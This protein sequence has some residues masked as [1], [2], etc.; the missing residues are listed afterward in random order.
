MRMLTFDAMQPWSWA[1]GISA[2][3]YVCVPG[4][5]EVFQISNESRKEKS[6][7]KKKDGNMDLL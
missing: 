1:L 6:I 4:F 3:A 5:S 2:P 7:Q